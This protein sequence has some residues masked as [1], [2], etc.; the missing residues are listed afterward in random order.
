VLWLDHWALESES[1]FLDSSSSLIA[2][3]IGCL[4]IVTSDAAI[5]L[6]SFRH[7][8]FGLWIG[9]IHDQFFNVIFFWY[10]KSGVCWGS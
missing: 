8:S 9:K 2:E 5:Y 1:D 4:G 6:L 10:S 7:L 3:H